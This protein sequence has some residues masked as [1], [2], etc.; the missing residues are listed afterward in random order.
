MLFPQLGLTR[1]SLPATFLHVNVRPGINAFLFCC[2]CLPQVPVVVAYLVGTSFF[3]SAVRHA[4]ASF[5]SSRCTDRW[6]HWTHQLSSLIRVDLCAPTAAL[7][8]R[9]KTAT[10]L[11]HSWTPE[12]CSNK[13]CLVLCQATP[14]HKNCF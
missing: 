4:T 2:L 14:D 10:G 3:N 1:V 13:R 6:G 5:K 8:Y 12:E 9:E 11:A 7:E